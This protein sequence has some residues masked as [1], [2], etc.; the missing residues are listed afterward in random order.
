MKGVP[1]I[2]NADD[3]FVF[4]PFEVRTFKVRTYVLCTLA[5]NTIVEAQEEPCMNKLHAC[6]ITRNVIAHE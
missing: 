6:C 4:N 2:I 5:G 3:I 1:L